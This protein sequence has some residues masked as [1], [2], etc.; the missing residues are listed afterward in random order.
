MKI[1]VVWIGATKNDHLRQLIDMYH[2]R[3]SHYC[4]IDVEE[5]RKIKKIKN[6]M[7]IR[8]SETK[9]LREA[10]KPGD[11]VVVLDESGNA[12]SSKELSVFLQKKMNESS[13]G[14]TFL[15]G[16]AYGWE[17]SIFD[18]A[19]IV[20]SLS[21]MTLTHDIARLILLEQL[22]RA[23]SILSGEKYHNA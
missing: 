20:L 6:P 18:S 23:F 8:Q 15:I 22:Y 13:P 9:V 5:I 14:I 17:S 16:G 11:F 3:L 19:N 7:Q 4:N 21:K 12:M 10:I 1:K 2:K